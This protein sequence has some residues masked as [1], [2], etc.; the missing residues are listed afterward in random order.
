MIGKGGQQNDTTTFLLILFNLYLA[1]E[2]LDIK[3]NLSCHF[4]NTN[5]ISESLEQQQTLCLIK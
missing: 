1:L 4:V 5:L 3:N 2:Y